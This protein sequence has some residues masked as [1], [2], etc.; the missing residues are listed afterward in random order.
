MT[1]EEF[2]GQRDRRGEWRE[3]D[4]EG[5]YGNR[6]SFGGGQ[7]SS[8]QGWGR[9]DREQDW[10]RTGQ[11][12]ERYTGGYS[13]G[14]S[15]GDSSSENYGRE[16]RGGESMRHNV[17]DNWRQGG[18]SSAR[19]YDYGYGRSGI[20][21]RDFESEQRGGGYYGGGGLYGGGMGGYTGGGYRGGGLGK[22]FDTSSTSTDY[23]D[24]PRSEGGYRDRGREGEGWWNKMTNEVSSWFGG[25]DDENRYRESRRGK[26]PR[27]Y[28]RSDERIK[29]DINE[30]L[31][32]HYALDATDIDIEVNA[33]EI[34]L[35]GS[36]ESRYEKRLAEDV[37][38]AVSGVKHVEN[39]LRVNRG[40]SY[41]TSMG[42][43]GT[44]SSLT[45]EPES[46]S[47]SLTTESGKSAGAR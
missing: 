15:R 25:E 14:R 46:D 12:G 42:S 28:T 40:G 8:E 7:Q 19:D 35:S 9:A 2:M 34:V 44:S 38:E 10:R 6:T 43:S 29:E 41:Q 23:S 36:V 37:V 20:S 32:D 21:E 33:G 18:G 17:E 16:G 13:G 5:R 45:S 27:G 11:G 47:T 1:S 3:E 39:R 22:N 24:Y 4:R 30:R 31:T 26:G